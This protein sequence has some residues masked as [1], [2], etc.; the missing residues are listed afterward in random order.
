MKMKVL[1]YFQEFQPLAAFYIMAI[2][3]LLN[4]RIT[5]RTEY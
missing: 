2:D 3:M 5:L 4:L 1:K